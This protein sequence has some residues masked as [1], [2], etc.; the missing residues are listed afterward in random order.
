MNKETN[1]I[2]A[3]GAGGQ[4][5]GL[6][7]AIAGNLFG[8]AEASAES[9]NQIT[10][11]E[12]L[13]VLGKWRWLIAG[14]VG[15]ALIIG[16][17]ST[18][19]TSK[20]YQATAQVE[21][22]LQEINL[23]PGK[24]GTGAESQVM[25]DP[26]FMGTQIG[27]LRSRDLAERVARSLD[28]AS[29]AKFAPNAG[30]PAAQIAA[31]TAAIAG[32]LRIDVV[33]GSRL[34]NITYE[35]GDPALAA[36]VANAVADNYI[37]S[38]LERK[39]ESSAFARKFLEQ[40]LTQTKAAL[41]KSE[42]DLVEYAGREKIVMVGGG[43]DQGGGKDGG[44]SLEGSTL[45]SLNAAL[46]TAQAERI[47]AEQK[48]RSEGASAG[49]SAAITSPAVNSLKS[50]RAK[51][52]VDFQEKLGT[53][54]PDYPEMV[55]LKTRMREL[56]QQIARAQGEITGSV[57]NSYAGEYRAAL[58]REQQLRA[59]VAQLT[60]GVLDLRNRQIQYNILSRE[61][62]T[63][64]SLYDGLLQRFKQVSV[65]GGVGA[66]QVSIVDRALVPGG[67]FAPNLR[68]NLLV[69]LLIGFMIGAG[70]AFAIEFVDDTIKN[71]DDVRNRLNLTLLG[72]V[73]SVAK[74]MTML[75]AL[76]D[77]SSAQSEAYLSTRTA[78]KFTTAG[79]APKSLLVTSSQAA[80]G[81]SSSC[82]AIARGF[83]RLGESVL[84][85]DADMRKPSFSVPTGAEGA[86][87][88]SLLAST[89]DLRKHITQTSV[90][91]LFLLPSG[92]I[93]PNPVELLG[94]MRLREV[95]AE[96]EGIFDIVI[97]DSPPVMGLADAPILASVVDASIFVVQAGRIRRPA[98]LR[99]LARLEQ[100]G[101]RVVGGVI[102]KFDLKGA[103]YGYGYGYGY[104]YSYGQKQIKS[105]EAGARRQISIEKE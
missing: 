79:G 93:P 31:A 43:A 38:N 5:R 66:S 68:N 29:R 52:Q 60:T 81:K 11:R 32:G 90:P 55:A 74:G 63:N 45:T 40:R 9:T 24:D 96:A 41:E 4:S 25:R 8:A 97:F 10:T 3:A 35:S 82:F 59:R 39:Y 69:S 27:L 85:I 21:L 80:E 65:A 91:N 15:A 7:H 62:D 101:A 67:P 48:Y 95:L 86:G 84:L 92:P 33:T 13:R 18:M 42:R 1:E 87:L 20:R 30:N 54:K 50:E 75:E 94:G 22:A 103:S 58:G 77:P 104:G 14:I 102:T 28:G 2:V 19:L 105:V 61:V 99:A 23:G 89:D 56:D 6:Q 12:A 73:P 44:E 98:A 64:R 16:I 36:N 76:D 57:T 49:Q 83:A 51:L 70:V 88:S 71:P 26:Q 46:A 17:V 100:A 47:A 78:I 37:A 34:I 53:F 72:V